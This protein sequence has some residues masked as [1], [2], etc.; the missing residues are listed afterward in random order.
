M[1]EMGEKNLTKETEEFGIRRREMTD[2]A[3]KQAGR[4]RF[5]RNTYGMFIHWGLYSIPGGIWNGEKMEDGGEGPCVAE[6]IMRR[7]GISRAEYARLADQFN[8]T[9][10]DADAWVS[11]A[12]A[13]GMK[14]IVITAKHHEG[15]ALFKSFDAFNA[16]DATP[17]GRDIIAE[18]HAACA[19]HGID[20][21]VYYSH[22]L[23]WRAG[24]DGGMKSFGPSN[25]P[26][27]PKF[28][29]YFDPS[30]VPFHDYIKNKS[31][32]QV[33]E[34]T[35]NY[36]GLCEIW[37][38]TPLYIPPEYSFEFYRYVYERQ[39]GMLVS[40]R[41]GN[42]M[43]DILIPGDNTIPEA[44]EKQPWECIATTNNSWG[45]NCYDQDWKSPREILFWLI[46]AVARGGNLLLN[47]GPLS[48]GELPAE[49]VENITVI[50]DWLK[51]NGEAVYDA[52][53]WDVAHEGPTKA[54]I[55]ST[56]QRKQDGFKAVFTSDDFFFTCRGNR[57]FAISLIP[58][59]PRDITIRS[60]AGKPVKAVRLLGYD[61]PLKW[62]SVREGIN[63][64]LP[65]GNLHK[66][67]A[68]IDVVLDCE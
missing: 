9:A 56:E 49:A 37:F 19:R 60:L 44:V 34:L 25:N 23:D 54:I 16:V 35:E 6:W 68:V 28:P 61:A 26:I 30:P 32:P 66:L 21:G 62:R 55:N 41:V 3:S 57:V 43:G 12:K 17:F 24:G 7:K 11:I 4:R 39:P 40:E 52:K 5:H 13:A 36:P 1:T 10:F 46:S 65:V 50:G 63:V 15:F 53:P 22:S 8:P 33:C 58:P 67:G 18:L 31:L 38:D 59:E 48:T 51:I 20:F 2:S 42:D 64:A 47:L 29:N 14:Y 27:C 45:Y